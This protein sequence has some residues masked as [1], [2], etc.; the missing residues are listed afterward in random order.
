MNKV[1]FALDGNGYWTGAYGVSRWGVLATRPGTWRIVALP[2][3]SEF[4][5]MQNATYQHITAV[6]DDFGNLVK[7]EA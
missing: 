7:V 6:M 1:F 3:V 4:M 5:R 2:I